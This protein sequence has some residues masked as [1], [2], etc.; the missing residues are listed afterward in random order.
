MELKQIKNIV[1]GALVAAGRPLTL[2]NFLALF[3][4]NEQVV[5]DQI[6]EVLAELTSDMEGRGIEIKKVASGFRLQVRTDVSPWITRLWAEKPPR[7]SRAFMETLALIVY[8]QPI[9][10]GEIE[11]IRGVSVSSSIVRSMLELEWIKVVGHRDVPGKP[12]LYST[13]KLFL[14]SFNLKSLDELPALAD[15]R[16][17]E[18]VGKDFNIDIS[19]ITP[20]TDSNQKKDATTSE[21]NET[22]DAQAENE[23]P[24]LIA[25]A[26]ESE[27]EENKTEENEIELAAAND[28]EEIEAQ[29]ENAEPELTADAEENGTEENELEDLGL[30]AEG[31]ESKE[32]QASSEDEMK[33]LHE[34]EANETISAEGSDLVGKN[35][36]D[37]YEADAESEDNVNLTN[38][39]GVDSSEVAVSNS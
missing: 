29:A 24:E 7:Y 8:R 4:E 35:A 11:S 14:D 6:K 26:E 9:T 39:D 31:A 18:E 34:A 21:I 20:L 2:D 30:T 15:I 22:A 10:R 36:T 19:S 17:L 12:A 1:E 5:R 27:P 28:E 16:S 25:D 13:T 37:T 32:Q 33:I 23:E 3:Q 38:A